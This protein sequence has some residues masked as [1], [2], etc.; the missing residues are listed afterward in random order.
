MFDRNYY[1][2]YSNKC[3]LFY[4]GNLIGIGHTVF[5]HNLLTNEFDYTYYEEEKETEQWIEHEISR[6]DWINEK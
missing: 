4:E 6:A 5:D 1:N 3:L 2:G